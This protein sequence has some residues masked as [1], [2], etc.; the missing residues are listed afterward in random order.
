MRFALLMAIFLAAQF[1]SVIYYGFFSFLT[2]G[3]VGGLGWLFR[4]YSSMRERL[5]TAGRP[6]S[7]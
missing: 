5:R 1:Y 2:I 7:P 4:A 3:L 6:P